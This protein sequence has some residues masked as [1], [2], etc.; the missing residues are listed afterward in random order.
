VRDA[1]GDITHFIAIKQDVTER[2]LAEQRGEAL[3]RASQAFSRIRS[4]PNA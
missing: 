1:S 4:T 3:R 2:V